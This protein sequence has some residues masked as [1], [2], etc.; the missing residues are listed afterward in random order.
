MMETLSDYYTAF[1]WRRDP[2][3]RSWPLMG[4][5]GGAQ[6]AAILTVYSLMVMFG[7]RLLKN[8]TPVNVLYPMVVYNV[9]QVLLCAYMTY[10]FVVAATGLQ[11]S[12]VC[13]RVDVSDN[14]YSLRLTKVSWLFM[15]SKI[16]DMCDTAFMLLKGDKRRVSFLHVFHHGS[17]F[18]SWWLCVMFAPGGV[19]YTGGVI[20][21]LVHTLM[22]AYYQLSTMG[23]EVRKHLWWK[24]YLTILQMVQFCCLIGIA[25]LTRLPG[26]RCGYPEWISVVT[27]FYIFVLLGLF[28]NFYVKTYV[29]VQAAKAAAAA[30]AAAAASREEPAPVQKLRELNSSVTQLVGRARFACLHGD[31]AH[32]R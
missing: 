7:Q 19:G 12:P 1:M 10:E 31:Q 5:W 21:S 3:V 30:A 23:P 4:P 29:K 18:Y 16:V 27:F 8:R 17:I 6:T 26:L 28:A 25:V 11:V 2:R 14:P 20:N 24:R 15:A 32:G 13:A 9:T 22:Y